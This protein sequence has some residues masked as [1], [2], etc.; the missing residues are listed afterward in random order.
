VVHFPHYDKDEQGPASALLLGNYK[1]IRTY[2]TGALQLFDL[3]DDLREEHD[4]AKTRSTDAAALNQRLTDYLKSV[5]AQMPATNPTFDPA[6]AR[7]FEQRRPG[8]R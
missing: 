8:R 3:A 7:P 2:E 4:L 1:L 5:N 6:K